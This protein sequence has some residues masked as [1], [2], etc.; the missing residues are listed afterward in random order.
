MDKSFNINIDGYWRDEHKASIPQ[1]SGIYFVYACEF[2]K[3]AKTVS[4]KKLIYIG[5]AGDVNARLANHEKYPKWKKHLN[6]T[7]QLCFSTAPVLSADRERVEAAY[8]FSHKPPENTEYVN[9]FPFDKTTVISTG[10]TALLKDTFAVI[11]T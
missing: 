1:H 7:Q 9:N 3:N 6:G 10:N 11:K 5:E 4:L 8:I 2:D